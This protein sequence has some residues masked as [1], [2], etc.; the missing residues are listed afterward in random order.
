MPNNINIIVEE[1]EAQRILCALE[2]YRSKCVDLSLSHSDKK[3]R[4]WFRKESKVLNELLTKVQAFS[5][6]LDTL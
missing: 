6:G 1:D 4:V 3:S 5:G 2:H